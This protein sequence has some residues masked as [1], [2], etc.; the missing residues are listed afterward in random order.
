MRDGEGRALAAMV[1]EP[2]GEDRRASAERG[3]FGESRGG[4]GSLGGAWAGAAAC[5]Q[6]ECD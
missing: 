1:D 2:E 6:K 5:G 4:G 3:D